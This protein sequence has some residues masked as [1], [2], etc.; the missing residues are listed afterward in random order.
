STVCLPGTLT[1]YALRFTSSSQQL[2]KSRSNQAHLVGLQ[3]RGIDRDAGRRAADGDARVAVAQR[4]DQAVAVVPGLAGGEVH[5]AARDVL[6]GL[7]GPGELE[8]DAGEALQTL[9][10]QPEVALPGGVTGRVVEA[11]V[12]FD[13]GEAA[14]DVLLADLHRPAD[15]VVRITVDR[16][17]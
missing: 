3:R 9:L 14:D 1:F 7:A 8:R 4:G 2:L 5:Q 6:A 11:Q 17:G 10:Q 13:R 15:A 16:H 12:P